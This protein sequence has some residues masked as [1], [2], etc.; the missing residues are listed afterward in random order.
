MHITFRMNHPHTFTF[1]QSLSIRQLFLCIFERNNLDVEN[2]LQNLFYVYLK[3]V[4]ME[5]SFEPN[6]NYAIFSAFI[7]YN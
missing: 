7:Y 4:R 6:K 5:R 2:Y 3:S 1:K